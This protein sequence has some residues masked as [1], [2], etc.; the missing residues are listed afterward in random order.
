MRRMSMR[1]GPATHVPVAG[2][3]DLARAHMIKAEI[4]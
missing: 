3:R 1:P 4:G 2:P